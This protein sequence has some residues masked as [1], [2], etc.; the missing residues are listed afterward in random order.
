MTLPNYTQLSN[1][2]IDKMSK[3]K[4]YISVVFIAISRK[5]IGWHKE[6]DRISYSQLE[7]LTGLCINTIKKAIKIL[8]DDGFIIQENTKNGYVYDLAIS[9]RDSTMK[10][11]LSCHDTDKPET[12]SCHDTDTG[13]RVSCG[14]T[15]KETSLRKET[16]NKEK[17]ATASPLYS[18]IKNACKEEI[19]NHAKEGACIKKLIAYIEGK[20]YKGDYGGG[21]FDALYSRLE[22]MRKTGDAFWKTRPLTPSGI[23]GVFE[24]LATMIPKQTSAPIVKRTLPE[25]EAKEY[26]DKEI[27]F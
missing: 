2:F 15:T 14:D 18:Y 8:I 20:G 4:P 6:S 16:R 3:Y 24:Q 27:N 13:K 17:E 22:K 9:R 1:D 10:S 11:S 5:T 23:L 19:V 7:T 25:Q 26:D 12:L 21:Y